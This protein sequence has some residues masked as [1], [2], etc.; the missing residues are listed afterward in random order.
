MNKL[1]EQFYAVKRSD[2]A[3]RAY[4]DACVQSVEDQENVEA[5]L[6]K[7]ALDIWAV[8][9][10]ADLNP[11][12]TK[13]AREQFASAFGSSHLAFKAAENLVKMGAIT[14]RECQIV[15]Q[16]IINSAMRD[17]DALTKSAT[18]MDP[19]MDYGAQP[20]PEMGQPA[21]GQAAE[22]GAPQSPNGSEAI[23]QI[24][25]ASVGAAE[26]LDRAQNTINNL[27]FLA[28]QVQLP[29]LAQQIQEQSDLLLDHFSKGNSYLPPEF[30]H[31]FPKSEHA[32]E[33]LKKYKQR[34]G[35]LGGGK[36]SAKKGA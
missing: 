7:I 22:Q 5:G 12:I 24:E 13:E 16:H 20:S 35:A 1:A 15:Q 2:E 25:D 28:Q 36:S 9:V 6:A 23:G 33:F 4:W 31:H 3:N 21:P 32:E 8:A 14:A 17:L 11:T 10:R 27:V 34:F 18:F 26:D 19:N 30:Q 29:Q